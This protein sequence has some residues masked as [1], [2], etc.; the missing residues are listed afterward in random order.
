VSILPKRNKARRTRSGNPKDGYGD[1]AVGVVLYVSAKHAR[2]IEIMKQILGKME[3]RRHIEGRL[4]AAYADFLDHQR[5]I[6]SG[7]VKRSD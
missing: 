3:F 6:F 7:R 1:D 4:N 5:R 2:I